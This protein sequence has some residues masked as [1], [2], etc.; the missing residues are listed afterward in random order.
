MRDGWTVF[1]GSHPFCFG[2]RSL[3]ETILGF[4]RIYVV[5]LCDF[6][7]A[8]AGVSRFVS[9]FILVTLF[10]TRQRVEFL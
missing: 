9:Y 8:V 10:L 6:L 1:V 2:M 5:C 7:R 3:K 4:V